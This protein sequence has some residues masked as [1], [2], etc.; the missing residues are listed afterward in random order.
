MRDIVKKNLTQGASGFPRKR[1][2][3]ANKIMTRCADVAQHKRLKSQGDQLK[4][5][6]SP[7]KDVS[8]RTQEKLEHGRST[9]ESV[10]KG[11]ET[12]RFKFERHK[13]ANEKKIRSMCKCSRKRAARQKYDTVEGST[14]SYMEKKMAQG[15]TGDVEAPGSL[16]R[17]NE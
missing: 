2:V 8:K 4:S 13:N 7:H 3:M 9:E 15:G 5:R 11:K 1:L 16:A 6:K 14:P 12:E 17:M 10:A